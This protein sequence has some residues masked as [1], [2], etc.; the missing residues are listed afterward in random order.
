MRVTFRGLRQER[1]TDNGCEL[2]NGQERT[3]R[4]LNP[5]R[6]SVSVFTPIAL[7]HHQARVLWWRLSS[8]RRRCALDS[9][10]RADRNV[11]IKRR[12]APPMLAN[13][14]RAITRRKRVQRL[15]NWS[16]RKN[17]VRREFR[18]IA[19]GRVTTV[20]GNFDSVEVTLLA[21]DRFPTSSCGR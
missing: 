9:T 19:A 21:G 12:A 18:K 11:S 20:D 4:A 16:A 2:A 10:T 17:V 14:N 15:P 5:A 1:K 6:S 13:K 3:T 8:R 7:L